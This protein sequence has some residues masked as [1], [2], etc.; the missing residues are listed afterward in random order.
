MY[1]KWNIK[2][3]TFYTKKWKTLFTFLIDIQQKKNRVTESGRPEHK[4][5]TEQVVVQQVRL[6]Q[7]FHLLVFFFT[8]FDVADNEDRKNKV[9]HT[10][11][12]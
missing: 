9:R 1:V 2:K 6:K 11:K 7:P 8:N 10:M 12:I 3:V 4:H 5:S